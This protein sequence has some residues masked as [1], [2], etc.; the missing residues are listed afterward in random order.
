MYVCVCMYIHICMYVCMYMYI[1]IYIYSF[2]YVGGLCVY[3]MWGPW[4]PTAPQH[5]FKAGA[6]FADAVWGGFP[7]FNMLHHTLS[8][9][10]LRV[11][12]ALSIVP[13]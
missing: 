3:T 7:V 9:D 8:C 10:I 1:Y 2:L 11:S 4:S 12:C 6:Y 13:Y 5:V